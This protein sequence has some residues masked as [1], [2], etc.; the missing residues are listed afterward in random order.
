MCAALSIMA[1]FVPSLIIL[2]A[3]GM[4]MI[5][6][7]LVAVACVFF[8]ILYIVAAAKISTN[9]GAAGQD[10]AKLARK[11]AGCLAGVL[12]ANLL[13][14]VYPSIV[15]EETQPV[16]NV[17]G[18]VLI[19]NLIQPLCYSGLHYCILHFLLGTIKRTAAAAAAAAAVENTPPFYP[20]RRS[21]LTPSDPTCCTGEEVYATRVG[22]GKKAERAGGATEMVTRTTSRPLSTPIEKSTAQGGDAAII[23]VSLD[24]SEDRRR[25][26]PG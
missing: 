17:I 24:R 8:I 7:L 11:I 14:I 21:T 5:S 18:S 10:V 26:V 12:V 4:F 15:R 9:L 19:I 16:A 6:N 23:T 25:L 22:G 2:R 20:S 1:V 3:A 13:Y